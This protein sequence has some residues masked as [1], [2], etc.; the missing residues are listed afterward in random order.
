MKAFFFSKEKAHAVAIMTEK[1]FL[2]RAGSTAMANGSPHEKR[3]R[4]LRDK[5]ISEGVL[6]SH[7][8]PDLLRFTRDFEFSSPSAAAGVVKDGNSSG[9]NDW[10]DVLSGKRM[11]EL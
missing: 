8:D 11:S 4:N 3:D 6:V 5:L 10:R 9:T 2:V 1:G 7:R